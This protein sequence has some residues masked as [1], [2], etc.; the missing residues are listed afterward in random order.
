MEIREKNLKDSWE[1]TILN[2][3]K[4]G[5]LCAS[6]DGETCWMSKEDYENYQKNRFKGNEDVKK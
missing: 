1:I 3:T 4:D 6:P 5:I 2:E